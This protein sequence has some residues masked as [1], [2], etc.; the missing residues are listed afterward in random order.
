MPSNPELFEDLAALAIG[1][2]LDVA[3]VDAEH[4]KGDDSERLSC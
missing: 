2:A 3:A 1:K 4:V